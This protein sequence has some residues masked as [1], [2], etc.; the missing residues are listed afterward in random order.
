MAINLLPPIQKQELKDEEL[1][2]KIIFILF[3]IL[4]DLLLLMAIIFCLYTYTS[5]KVSDLNQEVVQKE[6][7][8]KTP[9]SQEIKKI[10]EEAN[11]NLYKIN[12]VKKEQVSVMA[13]L[14]KVNELFPKDAYLKAFSFKNSF[15]DVENKETKVKVKEFFGRVLL[16]GIASS[17]ETIFSFKKLLS[18]DQNL[19]DVYFSPLSWVK[20]INADFM[21]DFNFISV[22][23]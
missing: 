22:K 10:I 1:R 16:N 21:V 20:A 12:S 18:Q 5:K 11:Q 9:Q 3:L 2:K 8:L 19:Q 6:N 4:L 15:R 23:K 17:R 14:E 13:V 7:L